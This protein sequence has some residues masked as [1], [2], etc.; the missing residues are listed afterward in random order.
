MNKFIAAIRRHKTISVVVILALAAA[1]YFVFKP[2]SGSVSAVV[3]TYGTA[4]PGTISQSVSGSGQIS[5]SRQTDIKSL[6]A[7]EVLKVAVSA[8]QQVKAGTVI[9]QLDDKDAQ[10]SLRDA[11]EALET[12]QLS[13]EKLNEPA[14]E[15]SLTQTEN[16]LK[17]ANESLATSREDLGKSYEQGFNSV[18][19][20]FID[21]PDIISGLQDIVT[22]SSQYIVQSSPSYLEYYYDNI[23]S[24]D[25]QAAELEAKA[26][27]SY[28]KAK[29]AYEKNFQDYKSVSQYSD[30]AQIE[31]LIDETYQTSKSIAEAAKNTV[32]LIQRYK[33]VAASRNS[34][35]QSFATTQITAVSGYITKANANASSLFSAGQNIES[36]KNS[37]ITSQRTVDERTQS[38]ENL[39]AGPDT[40]DVRSQELSIS[41]KKRAVAD[42]VEKITEYTIIAPFD[43]MI[44]SVGVDEGD[45]VSANASIATIITG[46]Q[47]ATISLNEVDIAKVK[48]GQKTT[49]TFSAID[50]LTMTGKVAEVSQIGAVSQG[51]VTYD[52]I[53]A[54]D[55]EDSQ[56]K[57][58]MSASAVIITQIKQ[59]VLLVLNAAVKTGNDG[60]YV[61]L[62]LSTDADAGKL[63][64]QQTVTAGLSD[65]TSTEI[66]QGLSE[67]DIFVV[68]SSSKATASQSSSSSR[69]LFN[70][71]GGGPGAH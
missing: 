27:S 24:Y 58:G 60:S 62:V 66:I 17:Q 14:D 19:S 28:Q 54:L 71:G 18:S 20:A 40:L 52:V 7:G 51:V 1:G 29:A 46:N 36:A 12:A 44:A 61:L 69:S 65:D 35:P 10:N 42:A 30:K 2:K 22:G 41:Q 9:A 4:G 70:M 34:V 15:L 53:I 8:G 26:A 43:G 55:T 32:I 13:L 49:L 23:K 5:A 56:V 37:I 21:F 67:G 63:A 38:L 33:D 11:K 59:N 64:K 3:Y 6:A 48:V 16:S 47:I 50:G 39:L 25:A 57:S 45:T 31:S 68:S